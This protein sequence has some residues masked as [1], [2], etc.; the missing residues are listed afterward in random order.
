MV[1]VTNIVEVATDLVFHVVTQTQIV[2]V[3]VQYI[4]SIGW[5]LI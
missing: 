2:M 3:S 5:R 1:K 4:Q